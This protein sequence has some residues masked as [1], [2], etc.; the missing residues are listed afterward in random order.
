MRRWLV[1][2]PLAVLAAL[3]VLFV[4]FG[5]RRDP[6]VVPAALVGRPA[7]PMALAPLAGGPPRTPAEPGRAVLVNFF[8]SNC[9]PCAVEAPALAALKAQGVRL[10]GVSYRDDPAGA[11]GF[12]QARGDPFET[13]LMDPEGRA[14]L[15]WGVSGVPETFA[16]GPDG[17][18]L[19]KHSGA[20]EPGD[21]ER[22]VDAA[23]RSERGAARQGRA[24]G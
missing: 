6:H 11:R 23:E 4:G 21:A 18:V 7:P 24:P 9:A 2:A 10:V 20:L 15:D 5:L 3:A 14:G 19:A 8:A 13:V 16:V 1:W 17:R 12:L 22:L